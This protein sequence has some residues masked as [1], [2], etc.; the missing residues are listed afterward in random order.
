MDPPATTAAAT[1]SASDTVS[2][3]A[4]KKNGS[5]CRTPLPHCCSDS[6]FQ[7]VNLGIAA[8]IARDWPSCVQRF[9]ISGVK[10]GNRCKVMPVYDLLRAVI[11]DLRGVNLRIAAMVVA[12]TGEWPTCSA[13]VGCR[14]EQ[15]ATK[16][17]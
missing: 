4:A 13:V 10:L 11:P 1:R 5:A 12:S 8:E 17:A 7:G 2:F 9:V 15:G 6:G 16:A 3:V 14:Q